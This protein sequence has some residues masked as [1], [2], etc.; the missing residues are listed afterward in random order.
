MT[1]TSISI[2]TQDTNDV[3]AITATTI[4]ASLVTAG[5]T[6]PRC[7]H[8]KPGTGS[9]TVYNS[10]GSTGYVYFKAGGFATAINGDYTLTVATG[11][12]KNQ[13]LNM[14][15]PQVKQLD[16][17]LHVDFSTGFTGTIYARGEAIHTMESQGSV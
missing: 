9:V 12:T 4:D 14:I 2:L 3:T 10:S 5:A 16:G 17:S 13:M 6:F 8:V 7:F 15:E 1:R 11:A